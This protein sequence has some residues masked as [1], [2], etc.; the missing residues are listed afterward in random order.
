MVANPAAWRRN[1]S[2]SIRTTSLSGRRSLKR[3]QI[4]PGFST[5]RGNMNQE[6]GDGDGPIKFQVDV[7]V[8]VMTAKP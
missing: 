4:S 5:S 8:G 1:Q 7:I 6:G 2:A 3:H